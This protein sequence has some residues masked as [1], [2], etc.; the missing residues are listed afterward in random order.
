[1]EI[2]LSRVRWQ[3]QAMTLAVVS[4]I[5]VRKAVLSWRSNRRM[6]TRKSS[7]MACGFGMI[8]ARLCVGWLT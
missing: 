3:R 2:G 7:P 4:D 6:P 5:S 1:M 8:C